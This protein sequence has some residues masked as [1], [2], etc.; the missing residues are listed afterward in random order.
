MNIIRS[1]NVIKHTL[2]FYELL[3]RVFNLWC[4][5][6]SRSL[7]RLPAPIQTNNMRTKIN[8]TPN[9]ETNNIIIFYA[10]RQNSRF[11]NH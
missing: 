9:R 11:E 5:G 3:L 2:A 8:I 4:F 10:S 7:A 1:K 6:V